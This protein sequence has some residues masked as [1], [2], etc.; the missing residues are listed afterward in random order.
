MK[1][2]T[3]LLLAL[4]V[5]A[6]SFAQKEKGINL[7]EIKVTPPQFTGFN[8][9][10]SMV[11]QNGEL[12]LNN[13]L[14]QNLQY[15]EEALKT[16]CQGTEV[17]RFEVT[18]DGNLTNFQVVNSISPQIDKELITLLEGTNGMW[19]AGQNNGTPATMEKE[20]SVV[21][22]WAAC[23][24]LAKC[25]DFVKL[26]KVC[27][28]K[29]NKQLLVKKHPEKALKFYSHGLKYRPNEDCLL[30]ARGI[31]KYELGD[32]EGANE[33]W[34]RM[35]LEGINSGAIRSA[36]LFDDTSAYA[37]LAALLTAK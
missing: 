2:L 31:C 27:L 25:A 26:A 10:V 6:L 13:Y 21:Y 18:V 36:Q 24:G 11:N 16:R 9:T 20:V 14:K 4:L 28:K 37:E 22:K 34:K 7:D 29:G 12:P 8:N 35:S 1:T 19:A 5:S 3:I 30:M 15:P 33:D 32:K 17:I 23:E